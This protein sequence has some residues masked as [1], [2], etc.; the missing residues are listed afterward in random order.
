MYLLR[1]QRIAVRVNGHVLLAI[2]LDALGDDLLG[3]R[4]VVEGV[5]DDLELGGGDLGV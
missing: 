4:L 3:V 5:D 1:L 2:D